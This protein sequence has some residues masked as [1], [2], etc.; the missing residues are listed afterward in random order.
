MRNPVATFESI[1]DFYITYLETAFRIA[2]PIIQTQRRRLLEQ[3]GTFTTQPFI[4][5][6]PRYEG[7][8]K[9][10]DDLLDPAQGRTGRLE[11]DRTSA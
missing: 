9:R 1:R 4:E 5:P 6:L 3:F 8:G 7:S 10:I 2:S 11:G